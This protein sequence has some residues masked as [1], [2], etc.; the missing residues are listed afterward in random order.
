MLFKAPMKRKT[1]EEDKTKKNKDGD[2]IIE[3][4]KK[5]RSAS[6]MKK[7]NNASLLSFANDIEED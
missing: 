3:K 2:K 7:V 6:K 1:N 5:K 4:G